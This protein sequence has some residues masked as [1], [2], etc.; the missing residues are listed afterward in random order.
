MM[1]KQNKKHFRN[2]I[3][4]LIILISLNTPRSEMF[5]LPSRPE[6]TTKRSSS[7]ISSKARPLIVQSNL[8]YINNVQFEN[9]LTFKFIILFVLDSF[10]IKIFYNLKKSII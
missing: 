7:M 2:I 8:I 3:L 10:P 5:C 9:Y 6:M 4:K 1:I